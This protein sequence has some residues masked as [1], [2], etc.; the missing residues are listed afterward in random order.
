MRTRKNSAE[1]A[2]RTARPRIAALPAKIRKRAVFDPLQ[3]LEL[4]A[5]DLRNP[6]SG[7]LAAG[8]YLLEDAGA[9][10]DEQ[11]LAM[12]QS[13]DSSSRTMLRLIDDVIELANLESGELRLEIRATEIQCADG[14][15]GVGEPGGGRP[16]EGP[17]GC[18]AGW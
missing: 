8:Q 10:L 12:L 18:G 5:H 15:G 11:H 14:P 6:I 2:G 17:V 4:A 7:I 16:E 3:L 13:I 9:V 1:Q